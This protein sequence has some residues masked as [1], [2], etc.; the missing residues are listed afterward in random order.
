MG[1]AKVVRKY[2]IVSLLCYKSTEYDA[3]IRGA[4]SFHNTREKQID[5]LVP[6]C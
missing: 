3:T 6:V 1:L 4:F 5:E 2:I